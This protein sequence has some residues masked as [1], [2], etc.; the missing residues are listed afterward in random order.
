MKFILSFLLAASSALLPH[1][2]LAETKL[3]VVTTL[4]TYADIAKRVGGE[5][6]EVRFIASPKFDPHFIEPK[7][8]DVLKVKK[9]DLFIHSGLDLEAW[10]DALLNA[11]ARSDVRS[12][13]SRQLD[14]SVRI[15]LLNVPAQPLSRAEGDIHMFGNPHYWLDPRNALIIAETITAKLSELDPENQSDYNNQLTAFRSELSTRIGQWQQ[16]LAQFKGQALVGYHDG[17]VY[18]MNF[19][20]LN[21]DLFLEPKAGIPPTPKQIEQVITTVRSRKIPAMV[22]SFYNSP[23]AAQAVAKESGAKI[24]T[25]SNSVG[26]SSE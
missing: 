14:L 15:P 5:H 26:D 2:L 25:L 19:S 18:L 1:A 6:I 12:G 21:M 16:S 4:S 24:I 7:P 9:A 20:G 17:W 22:L 3:K 10:R 11:A 13:G 23:E 8:S